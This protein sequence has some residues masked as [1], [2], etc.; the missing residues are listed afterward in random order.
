MLGSSGAPDE[1]VRCILFACHNTAPGSRPRELVVHQPISCVECAN[2]FSMFLFA[3]F[4]ICT[5]WDER[6]GEWPRR[7]L[8]LVLPITLL[9]EKEFD[10]SGYNDE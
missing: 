3:E 7:F 6:V 10:V 8:H 2:A 4:R 5:G 1:S 9:L